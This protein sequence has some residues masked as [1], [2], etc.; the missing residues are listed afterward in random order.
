MEIE[1]HY[2]MSTLPGTPFN[3]I[4][5]AGVEMVLVEEESVGGGQEKEPIQVVELG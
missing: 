4:R 2:H 3:V 1:I 5:S